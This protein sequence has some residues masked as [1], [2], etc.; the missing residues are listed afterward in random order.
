MN[1]KQLRM[2]MKEDPKNNIVQL[3]SDSYS[4]I[5]LKTKRKNSKRPES[6]QSKSSI[7]SLMKKKL[8]TAST[9]IKNTR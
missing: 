5:H 9:E 2:Q 4:Y 7:R 1:F 8:M 6:A 3:L